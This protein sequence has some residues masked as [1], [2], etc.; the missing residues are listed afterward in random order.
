[1]DVPLKRG[2]RRKATGKD[3]LS[4][5]L[6]ARQLAGLAHKQKRARGFI[7]GLA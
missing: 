4:R 7:S 2:G 3:R 6:L 1:M 5:Y